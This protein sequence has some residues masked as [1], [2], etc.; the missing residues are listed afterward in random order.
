MYLPP[1]L[2]LMV[3]L[4]ILA[5]LVGHVIGAFFQSHRLQKSVPN[6]A[7]GG[8]LGVLPGMLGT[9]QATEVIKLLL[10]IGRALNWKKCS[11][12]TLCQ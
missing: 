3:R 10:G 1:S 9:M 4:P 8:V 12:S 5:L 7:E 2:D 6:C 11:S